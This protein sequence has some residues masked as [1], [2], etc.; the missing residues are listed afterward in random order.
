METVDTTVSP[1]VN[2]NKFPAQMLLK[3]DW[4]T[5]EPGVSGREFGDLQLKLVPLRNVFLLLYECPNEVEVL[6]REN[7]VTIFVLLEDLTEL[8]RLLSQGLTKH[9]QKKG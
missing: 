8:L 5:I 9:V 3:G 4:L 2:H 7:I 1:K 6:L